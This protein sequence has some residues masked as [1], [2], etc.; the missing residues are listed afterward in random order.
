M[1]V[2]SSVIAFLDNVRDQLQIKFDKTFKDRLVN[3]D[4][5]LK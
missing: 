1:R 2:P 3:I 5:E 4:F